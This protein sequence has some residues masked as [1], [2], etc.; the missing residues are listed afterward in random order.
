MSFHR[1]VHWVWPFGKQTNKV[2]IK[3]QSFVPYGPHVHNDQIL[4]MANIEKDIHH[5]SYALTHAYI[6][7]HFCHDFFNKI[8][9][10]HR[11]KKPCLNRAHLKKHLHNTLTQF[12]DRHLCI[13][14]P[15]NLRLLKP[16]ISWLPHHKRLNVLIPCFYEHGHTW[17]DMIQKLDHYLPQADYLVI[18]LRNNQGG[19]RKLMYDLLN[20]IIGKGSDLAPN[21]TITRESYQDP[22]NFILQRNQ[23]LVQGLVRPT[24]NAIN[25]QKNH[26]KPS[27]Q[28]KKH[29][30]ENIHFKG[31]IIIL[32]NE[33]TASTSE[34]FILSLHH[35]PNRLLLGTPT[36]GS[37]TNYAPGL[38]V[39]PT[40]HLLVDIPSTHIAYEGI[41]NNQ[42]IVP[43]IYAPTI[44]ALDQAIKD[45]IK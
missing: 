27:I 26:Q 31:K 18:D 33:N 35:H 2:G 21:R 42:G 6:G 19:H 16:H 20:I 22:S 3:L 38:C 23:M 12:N 14:Q 30:L 24:L 39:L 15:Q 4:S 44:T 7:R 25:P 32:I 43:D 34:H 45:I 10:M 13:H 41:Q 1:I 36:Q 40:T 37:F 28:L 9:A 5:L 29:F 11:V 17:S 8:I